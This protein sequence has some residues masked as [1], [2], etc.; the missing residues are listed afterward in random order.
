MFDAENEY[1]R[2]CRIANAMIKRGGG[3]VRELGELWW[4]TD[5]FNKRKIK[6][7][8]PEYWSEY[9]EMSKRKSY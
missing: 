7:T 8:W 4:R 6:E 5:G 3:F 9:D 2:D 1:D